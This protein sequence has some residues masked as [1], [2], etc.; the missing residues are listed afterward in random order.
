ML[1]R[2]LLLFVTVQK[3]ATLFMCSCAE[4]LRPDT[5]TLIRSHNWIITMKKNTIVQ[6]MKRTGLLWI[7]LRSQNY[8]CC[9][10]VCFHI[11]PFIPYSIVK[12]FAFPLLHKT[13]WYP[14]CNVVGYIT[15]YYYIMSQL[16]QTVGKYTTLFMANLMDKPRRDNINHIRLASWMSEL[17]NKKTLES[18]V[19]AA[20]EYH[21]SGNFIS[22]KVHENKYI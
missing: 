11:D 12:C 9:S 17:P 16:M 22:N 21:S 19:Y 1:C 15:V 10:K 8:C 20:I 6:F 14:I 7:Q 4:K 5:T 18:S 2:I 3:Y 13:Q